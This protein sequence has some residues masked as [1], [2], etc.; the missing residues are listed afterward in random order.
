MYLT[1]MLQNL[2]TVVLASIVLVAV[3]GLIDLSALRRLRQLSR[4]EFRNAMVALGGVLL[5]GILKGVVLAATVSLLLVIAAAAR[6]N[7]A[8]LGR[9]PG[10][11]RY[12]DLQRNPDNEPV[13]GVLIFRVEASVLYFNTDHVRRTVWDKTQASD[14]PKMVLCDLSSSPHVDV[15]GARM[16]SDL[17]RDLA[18]RGISL[19]LAEAHAQVRDQL[20][21]EGLE[22]QVGYFGRHMSVDQAIT[23]FQRG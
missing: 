8:F 20:R 3:R 12:S 15:A 17:R 23:E 10:S 16:F 1:G 22:E 9:I 6:P 13:P 14:A 18:A 19:R 21:A 7:I 4:I 2:P 11:R 5:L